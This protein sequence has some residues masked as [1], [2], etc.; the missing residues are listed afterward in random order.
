MFV[1]EE[2]AAIVDEFGELKRQVDELSERQEQLRKQLIDAGQRLIL[3]NKFVATFSES[4]RRN[5]KWAAVVKEAAVPQEIVD[6]FTD[7]KMVTYVT[8]TVRE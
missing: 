8:C 3:G 7:N 4:P 6:K 2:L 1:S 5:T